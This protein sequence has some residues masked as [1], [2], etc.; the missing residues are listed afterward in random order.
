MSKRSFEID[1]KRGVISVHMDNMNPSEIQEL[2]SRLD[3]NLRILLSERKNPCDVLAESVRLYMG[4]KEM[5]FHLNW[6][7]PMMT[8]NLEDGIIPE[9]NV[10]MLPE[11][12]ECYNSMIQS[13]I[14]GV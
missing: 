12:R 8:V 9:P 3:A 6:N 2:M 13:M 4:R 5:T 10:V 1:P 14:N 11:E 7:A